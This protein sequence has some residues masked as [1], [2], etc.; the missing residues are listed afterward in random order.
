MKEIIE[1]IKAQIAIIEADI[2]K[3]GVKAASARV[4]K[5]TLQL[6]KLGKQYRKAS[7]EA[8]K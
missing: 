6:E 5:A 2:D 8:E 4:R 3:E 1:G 7:V